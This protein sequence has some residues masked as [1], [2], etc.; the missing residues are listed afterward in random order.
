MAKDKENIK[1]NEDLLNKMEEA[2][3]FPSYEE[4]IKN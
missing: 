2:G 3:E 4:L 1:E